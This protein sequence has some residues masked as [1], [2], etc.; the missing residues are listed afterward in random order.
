MSSP[1][2]SLAALAAFA[3]IGALVGGAL[4]VLW[5]IVSPRVRVVVAADGLN[6][7]QSTIGNYMSMD[8]W[9]CVLA[10]VAGIALAVAAFALRRRSD[11]MTL[12]G[13]LVA[14]A[15]GS[16]LMWRVGLLLGNRGV[17]SIE[18]SRRLPV[19]REITGRLV[20]SSHAALLVWAI[21][22]TAAVLSLSIAAPDALAPP[23]TSEGGAPNDADGDDPGQLRDHGSGEKSVAGG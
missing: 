19:G 5:S 21:A 3:S 1:R 18:D 15:V 16:V 9:F 12:V 4:G 13:L 14:A 20:L 23:T 6:Y 11:P 10:A 22:S 2:R 8:G 17:P 7:V